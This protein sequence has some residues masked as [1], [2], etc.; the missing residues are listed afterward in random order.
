MARKKIKF[1]KGELKKQRDS[2][3][4]FQRY[5]P[6]LQLKQQQLQLEVQK[7]EARLKKLKEEVEQI[8]EDMV[9]WIGVLAEP[10][11]DLTPWV[12]PKDVVTST[13]NIAGVDV[14]VF[15]R[16][17]FAEVDYD[18]FSMPLWVDSAVDEIRRLSELIAETDIT[19]EEHNILNRELKVTMQRVNLFE[20]V[21]IPESKENIRVIQIYLGDQYTNAVGRSK[22]AKRKIEVLLKT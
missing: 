22:I 6:I 5:L 13:T 9:S 16:A 7:T 14:P 15:K 4:Q 17:D 21:K 10:K 20:K 3:T 19:Q 1:T 12:K 11:I 2:K 18:I 8:K